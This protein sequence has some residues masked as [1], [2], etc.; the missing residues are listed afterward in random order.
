MR[1]L[2]GPKRI[3]PL[4]DL[5]FLVG[6]QAG[7]FHGP[8]IAGTSVSTNRGTVRLGSQSFSECWVTAATSERPMFLLVHLWQ[9]D[10]FVLKL[11]EFTLG[12]FPVTLSDV[13]LIAHPFV[14]AKA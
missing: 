10:V 11:S 8:N 3:K 7:R 2:P 12:L 1:V 13:R 9:L 5:E 6:F 4:K 14:G